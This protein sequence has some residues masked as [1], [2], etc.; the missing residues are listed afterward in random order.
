MSGLVDFKAKAI[1]I[2]KEAVA[3]DNAGNYENALRKYK[4]ALEYFS[5]HLKY[6]KNPAS[7]KAITAKVRRRCVAR[8]VPFCAGLNGLPA[9][10]SR[11]DSS[12]ST[13]RAR[14]SC[15]GACRLVPSRRGDAAGADAPARAQNARLAQTGAPSCTE[16][17]QGGLRQSRRRR[18]R[19][20]RQRGAPPLP[21]SAGAA[22]PRRQAEQRKAPPRAERFASRQ[23]QETARL[24]GALGGAILT[25]KPNVKA[26]R[27]P[28]SARRRA[29]R[30]AQPQRPRPR[31]A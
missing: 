4:A 20:R 19:R 1:E 13:W 11:R 18:W 22:P 27:T 28:R 31:A 29:K 6:D 23:D 2:V 5:T 26:R 8:D 10:A 21:R 12:R 3:E 9:V 7:K 17:R 14:R 24:R 16:R 25:E 15:S 30:G